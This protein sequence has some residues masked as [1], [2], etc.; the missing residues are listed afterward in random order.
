MV[1]NILLD[2]TTGALPGGYYNFANSLFVNISK[3]NNY[4]AQSE[5]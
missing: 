3:S 2:I 1:I 5:K 4:F